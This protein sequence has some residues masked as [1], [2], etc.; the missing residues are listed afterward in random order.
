MY[1][2]PVNDND[3]GKSCSKTFW[4]IPLATDYLHDIN[5]TIARTLSE[6]IGSGD[7]TAGLIDPSQVSDAEILTREQAV[8]C[9]QDWVNEVFSQIDSTAVLKWMIQDGD[10]VPAGT[11]LC[12][13]HGK[14]QSLLTA[15]RTALNFLQTLSATATRTNRLVQLVSHTDVNLLDTRKTIPGLRLAQKY[16]VMTGGGQNHR[17]GLF[18]AFLIKE[19][20]IA[21][22]GSI[23]NAVRK[24]RR[25]SP[26][27]MLEV[28]VENLD[29]LRL[30]LKSRPDRILLDNFNV[31]DIRYAVIE[32][33]QSVELEASGDIESDRDLIEIAETG[34][35]FIS[36]GALTK[37]C[38]AIDLSMLF[39]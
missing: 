33:G 18:D 12:R 10:Q 25:L 26:G 39:I 13:I 22:S 2:N 27:T 7:I 37:H 29:E 38:R 1:Y 28:E 16:A 30:A 8:I 24:A 31:A 36:I 4:G 35:D 20:H 34:V 11:V 9:G 32:A 3:F 14:T 19:N 23:E 21:A 6:D 17:I 15:E 5:I